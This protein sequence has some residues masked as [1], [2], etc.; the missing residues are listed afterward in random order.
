MNI[1]FY[2]LGC[3]VN[4]YETQAMMRLMKQEGYQTAVYHPDAIGDGVAAAVVINSCTVTGEST[5]KL[6]QLL[7]RLRRSHPQA[8]IVLTGCMP[9][10]FPDE[11]EALTEADIVTGN[12][13]RRDLPRLLAQFL[14]DGERVVNIP[15]HEKTIEPLCIDEFEERT[16]AFVKV[17]D[18]C[19]RFCSYCI[20]PFARGRV[21][22]R[23]IAEIVEEIEGLARRG[24][25]EVVLTGINLTAYGKGT[26]QTLADA[27]E[28]A[29]AVEGIER[30]RLGSLEPDYLTDAMIARLA[31]QPKLCAQ[32]HVALQ[33][34]SDAVLKAMNRHYTAAEYRAVCDKLKAAFADA[35]FTTDVMVGFPGETDAMFEESLAFVRE[36]GFSKVHVF[37]YSRRA[38]TKAATMSDQIPTAEKTRRAARMGAM[39]DEVRAQ[40]MQKAVGSVQEI[41]CETATDDGGTLG[42][43]KGYIPCRLDGVFQAGDTVTARIVGVANDRLSAQS[44]TEEESRV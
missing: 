43:T 33:S 34:G 32:F 1:Y 28:A 37:P 23:P 7:R 20:I 35:T 26:D 30:V 36:I 29:C 18:G 22:S 16:R 41:L 24:Y 40:L 15:P 19:D 38:G 4:Q 17:E 11:A 14:C 10:A 3:K 6:R 31:A 42:Y 5:R 44:I 8:V 12:A 2:T 9:Q 21:R 39:C 13:C 25:K 27:V